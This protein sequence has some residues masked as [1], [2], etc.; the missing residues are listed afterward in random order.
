MQ[1]KRIGAY[2]PNVFL[3]LREINFFK[4]PKRLRVSTRRQRIILELATARFGSAGARE[5]A[6]GFG[7]DMPTTPTHDEEDPA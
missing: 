1:A 6:R 7:W 2:D 3:R 5:L 4:R